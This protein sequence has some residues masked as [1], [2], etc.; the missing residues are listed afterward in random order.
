[1]HLS[2]CATENLNIQN[3]KHRFLKCNVIRLILLP[4]FP[5]LPQF[6]VHVAHLPL[7]VD[8]KQQLLMAD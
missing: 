7:C 4:C 2:V 1:M 6:V 8:L 3:S 5:H